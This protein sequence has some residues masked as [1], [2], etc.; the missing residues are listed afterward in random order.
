MRSS[1]RKM[2]KLCSNA[3]GTTRK[4][5]LQKLQKES[6]GQHCKNLDRSKVVVNLS[7]QMLIKGE[8]TLMACGVNFALAPKEVPRD[9][10]IASTE[11]LARRLDKLAGESYSGGGCKDVLRT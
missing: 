4:Q 6:R 10:I 5:T 9:E 8:E 7:Q 2:L 3:P 1:L 11:S